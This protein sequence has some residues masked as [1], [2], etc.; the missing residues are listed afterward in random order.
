MGI[1][2][3][4][5]CLSR[6]T[7]PLHFISNYPITSWRKLN[8]CDPNIQDKKFYRNT[9]TSMYRCKARYWT[10]TLPHQCTDERLNPRSQGL[11]HDYIHRSFVHDSTQWLSM[12]RLN[13]QTQ[14]RAIN[15]LLL[16][17]HSWVIF[18]WDSLS[19][20]RDG[21]HF[22][23]LLVLWIH[24]IHSFDLSVVTLPMEQGQLRKYMGSLMQDWIPGSNLWW[25]IFIGS[26]IRVA[27]MHTR[28]CA[29]TYLIHRFI[30]GQLYDSHTLKARYLIGPSYITLTKF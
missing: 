3:G 14:P 24:N 13:D 28:P 4:L 9:P 11:E 7:G 19:C 22:F 17:R 2:M 20:G 26:A 30:A 10:A 5:V 8:L 15:K 29:H 6:R 21:S 16:K 18:L 23:L 27:H 12:I 1:W 25:L